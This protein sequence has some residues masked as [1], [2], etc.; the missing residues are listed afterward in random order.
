MILKYAGLSSSKLSGAGGVD[1]VGIIKEWYIRAVNGSGIA[2][3][4]GAGREVF[5]LALGTRENG[6]PHYKT[7]RTRH[8]INFNKPDVKVNQ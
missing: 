1:H 2:C 3:V 6:I 5:G 8:T 4:K 7:G